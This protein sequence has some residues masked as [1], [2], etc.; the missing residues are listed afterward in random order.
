MR[1]HGL[2]LPDESEYLIN[3]AESIGLSRS[4]TLT[5]GG[6]GV[7]A[8]SRTSSTAFLP[9]G[10]DPVI[11]CIEKRIAA[12][13]R[14]PHDTLEPLQV[15][16]YTHNQE[17]RPHY[18]WFDDSHPTQRTTT[19]FAYLKG[20]EDQGGSK[21]GGATVF[22][23]LKDGE[24]TQLRASPISG[25][26]VVWNNLTCSGHGHMLTLH[27]GEP[28]LCEN[29]RKVGLNAW[30]AIPRGDAKVSIESANEGSGITLEIILEF[31]VV[32]VII[33]L[34]VITVITCTW[35]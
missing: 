18:D 15:T 28:V 31:A 4:K 34:F 17:Y 23:N 11:T 27:G 1:V 14:Q 10:K 32:A 13:A 20:L 25:D 12:V 6:G 7:I 3:R 2:I 35:G 21:C 24:L 33:L 9:K 5:P 29:A 26:A 22:P 16:E 30:F 8:E 19:V